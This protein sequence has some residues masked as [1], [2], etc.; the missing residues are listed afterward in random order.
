[1][2]DL[3]IQFDIDILLAKRQYPANKELEL[4]IDVYDENFHPKYGYKMDEV[5]PNKQHDSKIHD[6][7]Q[8]KEK[9]ED[10]KLID[11]QQNE[12]DDDFILCSEDIEN[13]DLLVYLHKKKRED[14]MRNQKIDK[15]DSVPSFSLGIDTEDDII[16]KVCEDIKQNEAFQEN[17]KEEFETPKQGIT[18]RGKREVKLGPYGKSPYVDRVI[19]ITAKYTNQDIALALYIAKT[20]DP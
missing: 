1:M 11:E 4:I 7:E 19:D 15:D 12:M 10:S 2:L 9:P 3:K 17:D 6:Q 18:E 20:N 14:E 8:Q 13:I 5:T 16:N